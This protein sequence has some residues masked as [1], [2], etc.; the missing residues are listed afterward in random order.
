MKG[1]RIQYEQR[2]K[3]P[4]NAVRVRSYADSKGITVAAVYK[5]Y[6]AGKLQIITHQD[7]NFVIDAG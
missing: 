2:S 3:L 6:K 5:Q 4:T 1:Q 7:I